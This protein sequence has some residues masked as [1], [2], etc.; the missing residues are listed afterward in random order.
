MHNLDLSERRAHSVVLWFQSHG[1]FKE[2]QF[3]ARGAGSKF[4]LT[5]V[6]SR[7]SINR[8]V[9]IRSACNETK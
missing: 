2:D 4:P 7:L 9:E 6:M 1:K 3:E 8:R 5:N